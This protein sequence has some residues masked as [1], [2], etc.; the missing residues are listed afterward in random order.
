MSGEVLVADKPVDKPGTQ[1]PTD[2]PIRI[3][4][5]VRQFVSRGGEKLEAGLS[6]FQVQLNGKIAIDVGASTGGFT[7]CMLRRGARL[8]YAVDVGYNQLDHALRTDSRVSVFEKLNAKE[9]RR[10]QFEPPP[11]FLAA[12]LS[13]IGLRKVLPA[14]FAVMDRPFSGIVLVKPQFELEREDI[15]KGGV[16]RS[17]EKQQRAVRLVVDS[18]VE[19]GATV[20]GSIPSPIR[21]EK[22]GNQEFLLCFQS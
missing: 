18:V 19:L 22:K 21:G 8:V 5:E 2:A 10:E 13:F 17:A 15:E 14:I 20:I 12:D 7:D 16:V 4:G 6:H 1:V 3:R 11:Q 9:L